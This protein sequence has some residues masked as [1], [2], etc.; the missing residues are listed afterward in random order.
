MDSDTHPLPHMYMRDSN[1]KRI[2]AFNKECVANDLISC[3]SAGGYVGMDIE[4]RE[5]IRLSWPKLKTMSVA[6]IREHV[7]LHATMWPFL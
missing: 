2:D 1:R 6:E 7:R 5:I 4:G 3:F